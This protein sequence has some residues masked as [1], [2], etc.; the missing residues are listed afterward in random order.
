MF[1]ITI[2]KCIYN[3]H[4]YKSE[5]NDSKDKTTKREELG[6]FCYYKVSTLPVKQYTII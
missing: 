5:M 3:T 1:K 4:L 2:E 6:L